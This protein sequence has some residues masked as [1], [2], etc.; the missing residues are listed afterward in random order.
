MYEDIERIEK[1]LSVRYSAAE[2]DAGAAEAGPVTQQAEAG[3]SSA[4]AA[5][6]SGAGSSAAGGSS[7]AAAGASG[8]GGAGAGSSAGGSAGAG[9]DMSSKTPQAAGQR[10]LEFYTKQVDAAYVHCQWIAESALLS[11]A[12]FMPA[13]K[14]KYRNF[15]QRLEGVGGMEALAESDEANGL[16][17]GV[18]PD[19]IVAQRVIA[20]DDSDGAGPPAVCVRVPAPIASC[21]AFPVAQQCWPSRRGAAACLSHVVPGKDEVPL[22]APLCQLP[23]VRPGGGAAHAVQ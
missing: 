5:G 23:W 12:K 14:S 22:A 18:H 17:H 6:A 2:L 13:I 4:A 8:S 10:S 9:S 3:G 11:A 1:I 7:A 20:F 19:W 15:M 16:E 21:G